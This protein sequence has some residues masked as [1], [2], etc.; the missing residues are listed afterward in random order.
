MNA[1]RVLALKDNSGNITSR[2]TLK[3]GPE[4]AKG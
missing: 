1:E 3:E 2:Q 4:C